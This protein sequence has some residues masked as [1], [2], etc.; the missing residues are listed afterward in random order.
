MFINTG[1]CWFQR[2]NAKSNLAIQERMTRVSGS[3]S[4]AAKVIQPQSL[5]VPNPHLIA[6][7][8]I[9]SP[10][11]LEPVGLCNNHTMDMLGAT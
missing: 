2:G 9:S 7:A 6:D 8:A 3:A 4:L 5:S 10:R 1:F 11:R